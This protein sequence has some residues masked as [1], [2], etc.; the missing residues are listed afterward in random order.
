MLVSSPSGKLLLDNGLSFK[1]LSE[2]VVA[3]GESLDDLDA[4]FITHEHGDH[5]NGVG[6]LARKIDVPVYL[7]EKTFNA[8]PK[9]V[10]VIPRPVFFEA[11][12]SI[13]VGEFSVDSFTVP[14]DA[15]DPVSFVVRYQ[16][17]QLGLATDLGKA[18]NVVRKRLEGSHALILESNYCPD[19]L[20]R[21]SYPPAIRQRIRGSH[22]HLSN[23]DM[24]SLLSD[25]IH[26]ELQLVVAVHVSQENNTEELARSMAQRALGE[27]P[28]EL[29]VAQ[30][31][32]PTPMFTIAIQ[33]SSLRG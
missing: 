26:D 22:G 24:N 27:H 12:E 19:M 28:A 1:K 11:G 33:A 6:I 29:I 17:V 9:T 3:I 8:L 31:D 4:V 18:S 5:V 14:H 7:T 23:A 25:L 13:A 32:E 15:I 10:G 20:L 2:R 21:S 30:Q 16:E